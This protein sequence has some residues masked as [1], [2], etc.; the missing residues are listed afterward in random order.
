QFFDVLEKI[1]PDQSRV[2]H[3]QESYKVSVRLLDRGFY[4]VMICDP[5][6]DLKIMEDLSC[7]L[8]RVEIRS[9]ETIQALNVFS[10]ATGNHT[11]N[12]NHNK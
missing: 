7:H 10:R 9:W 12:E 6:T 11:V 3:I 8:N 4:S 5:K 1:Y 2:K